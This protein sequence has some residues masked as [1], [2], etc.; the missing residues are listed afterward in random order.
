M[1]I[2][3]V[4]GVDKIF[5]EDLTTSEIL[6]VSF[7]VDFAAE[8]SKDV[9]FSDGFRFV[10]DYHV[11][12]TPYVATADATVQINLVPR[13]GDPAPP[14]AKAGDGFGIAL[15]APITGRF[16]IWAHQ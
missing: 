9:T 8:D 6:G 3:R 12:I 10:G 13:A 4:N 11:H 5:L 1:K 2:L 14:A 7:D 15:S 16:H